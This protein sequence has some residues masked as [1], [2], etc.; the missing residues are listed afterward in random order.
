MAATKLAEGERLVTELRSAT[1]RKEEY[2]YVFT[3]IA[4]AHGDVWTTT[5]LDEANLNQ[6]YNQYRVRHGIPFPPEIAA[7]RN[8]YGLSASKMSEILGFGINQ[9]RQYEA[10]EMPSISNGRM[11]VAIRDQSVFKTFVEASREQLGTKEYERIMRHLSSLGPYV[12]NRG[13]PSEMSGFSVFSAERVRALVLYFVRRLGGVFVTKMNKLLFYADF[14]AYRRTG[15]GLTGL[16]YQAMQY[17]P[18]PKNWGAVYD[19]LDGVA[20]NEYVINDRSGGIRLE[21]VGDT[22]ADMALSDDEREIL[23]DVCAR[24]GDANVKEISDASHDE[25]GWIENVNGK[26]CISYNY[27]FYLSMH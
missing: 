23:E 10:G 27:A 26:G 2:R 8:H 14:L 12:A 24:F 15:F 22:E 25:V 21:A 18:V 16:E 20:M 6:V 5:Q 17:G 13:E 4:D 7:L 1:F 9:Y 19:A 3:G 11:L